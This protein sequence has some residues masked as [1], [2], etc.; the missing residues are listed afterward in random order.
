[1]IFS[2]WK[3][4]D[5]PILIDPEFP[6]LL[7]LGPWDTI[8]I[9]VDGDH[10]GLASGYGNTHDSVTKMMV[11][12]RC[13]TGLPETYILF[14]EDGEYWFNLEDLTG[15]RKVSAERVFRRYF[16]DDHAN[17][18]RDVIAIREEG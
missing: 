1:M 9:C 11:A 18:L 4:E 8:R 7:R 16:S 10:I 6:E 5:Y 17:I 2:Q 15:G 14:R 3:T 12:H 13:S